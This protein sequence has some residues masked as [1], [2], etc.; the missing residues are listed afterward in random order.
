MKKCLYD[1]LGVKRDASQSEIKKAYKKAVKELHPDKHRKVS[2][3]KIDTYNE[4]FADV[5]EAYSI[6]S[7]EKKRE[8]YDKFG[9]F[10]RKWKD[11]DI[12]R[13]ASSRLIASFR[14]THA[15]SNPIKTLK[16]SIYNTIENVHNKRLRQLTFE[17]HKLNIFRKK[18]SEGFLK[19]LLCT[20]I[21]SIDREEENIKE[22]IEFE[23]EILSFLSEVSFDDSDQNMGD[24][25]EISQR[26]L[27]IPNKY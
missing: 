24:I 8:K 10:N 26:F 17:K 13:E 9:E 4:L 18:S 1:I 12:I 25:Y 6:L 20:C 15:D 7:D 23:K 21:D 2:Q 3:E 19:D 11:T 22:I 27:N 5:Q 16:D 14:S